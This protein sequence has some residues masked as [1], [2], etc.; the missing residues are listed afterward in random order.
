[1][2]QLMDTHKIGAVDRKYKQNSKMLI[3]LDVKTHH[4]SF[5]LSYLSH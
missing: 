2:L 5:L 3:S 4:T 1:V